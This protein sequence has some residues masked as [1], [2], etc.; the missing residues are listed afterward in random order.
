MAFMQLIRINYTRE[1]D[2]EYDDTF[3]AFET[4]HVDEDDVSAEIALEKEL[5]KQAMVA[6]LA[7]LAEEED[8]EDDLAP[9]M[10][11][12]KPVVENQVG[13]SKDK[14]PV[15]TSAPASA[16][17]TADPRVAQLPRTEGWASKNTD[18][19]RRQK[20]VDL[21][22]RTEESLRVRS[23][24]SKNKAFTGNHN[25]KDRS[26]MKRRGMSGAPPPAP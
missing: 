10:N 15:A 17:A 19:Y 4:L 20:G 21:S 3:E 13:E 9:N 6:A 2:D 25:R 11:R 18:S 23:N 12:V 8:K 22:V 1:Y 7:K 24:K 16:S 14:V 26:A 5:E